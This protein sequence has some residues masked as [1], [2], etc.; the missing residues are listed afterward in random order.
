M[1][2]SSR[3]LL[4]VALVASALAVGLTAVA[5]FDAPGEDG[6]KWAAGTDPLTTPEN[7][8]TGASDALSTFENE[9]EFRAYL[10]SGPDRYRSTRAG[11]PEAA[12]SAERGGADGD[13]DGTDGSG[14]RQTS[15]PVP[16]PTTASGDA[17]GGDGGSDTRVGTTNVQVG[18]VDEPDVLKTDGAHFYYAP[19]GRLGG[20]R[21]G[22]TDE[23]AGKIDV[24][25]VDQPASP[26]VEGQV[27]ATGTMLR[28]GD[29]LVVLGPNTVRGI[30]VSDPR[31]PE[32]AWT[33]DLDGTL[34]TAR[35]V[36]GT[37]YLVLAS[38]ADPDDPCPVRP[39]GGA[40]DVSCDAVHHPRDRVPVDATYTAVALDPE[41]GTVTDTTAVVGTARETAVYATDSRLYLTYTTHPDRLEMSLDLVIDGTDAVPPEVKAEMSAVR[42]AERSREWKQKRIREIYSNWTSSMDHEERD[43]TLEAFREDQRAYVR[44]HRRE[45]VTSGVVAVGLGDGLP[46]EAH[47]TV[48]GVPLNQF[49][50]DEGDGTLRV[51]TTVPGFASTDAVNDLYTLS[52]SRLNRTGAVQGMAPGQEIFAARYVGDTAYLV[53]FRQVDPFHVVDL[54]DPTA[55]EELGQVRL[56]GFSTYLHPITDTRIL[57]IGEE[58]GRVK[59]TVFDA[60]EPTDPVV[61]DDLLLDARFS[62]VADTHHAFTI[63]RRHGVFFL[64]AGETGVVVDYTDGTLVTETAVETRG[65]P[66]RRARYVGDYLYVFGRSEVVVLDETDWS[67]ADRLVLPT[68]AT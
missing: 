18:G 39:L 22:A 41:S 67:V 6:D 35:L 13:G 51:A 16:Q 48:P 26:T 34:V 32:A 64:P 28:T 8:T 60:S 5:L 55:P 29:S 45:L 40:A 3:R 7:D 49:S 42:D 62:A 58:N 11:R 15:T 27:D 46:V 14:A 20:A 19:L 30:D 4:L 12:A 9:S 54:S 56:P 23:A 37:V 52:A 47:G 10:E 21:A 17:A 25:N 65:G 38:P 43:R 1:A 2:S 36:D 68:V 66:P 44:E 57:G 50:L 53:T 61:Q 31:V 33:H 59:A 63:D 24:L